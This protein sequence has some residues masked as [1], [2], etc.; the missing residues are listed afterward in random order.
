MALLATAA[1]FAASDSA[2]VAGGKLKGVI[3]NGIASFKGIPFAA[4][5]VGDL[6]WRAPQP[7]AAWQGVRAADHFEHDCMQRKSGAFGPWSAEFIAKDAME[8]GSS[9]DCL[10]LNVWTAAAHPSEKRPVFVWIYGGGF[11]SGGASVPVYD[12][13]GLASKG[14]V[15]VVINYRVGI[16]GFMA[17]PELTKESGRNASGNYGLLDM[18]AALRWVKANAGA[19][20]GDASNVTI[21]GQSAGAF[22]VNYLVASPLAKGLFNRAI[23][24]SG[25]VFN[26]NQTL[27]Q[28]EANGVSF[29]QKL[30]AANLAEMRAKSADAVQNGGGRGGPIVDGYFI[31]K[32]VAELFAGG[33]QNDVPVILGWNADDGTSF[34]TP[35]TPEAFRANAAR[36]YG[37]RAEEF[38]KA[39]PSGT[40]A[41]ATESQRALS[42]I[43]TFAWQSHAWAEA[44]SRSGKSKIYLY[45]FDRTAPG[46]PEQ[47]KY[48]AHHTGEVPYAL[49]TLAMWDRPFEAADRKLADEMSSYWVNFARTGNPN[50]KALPAWPAYS[51]IHPQSMELSTNVHAIPTPDE[52][53][54]TFFDSFYAG[55]RAQR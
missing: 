14:L 27:R 48:G 38:L 10:Y 30:G 11:N 9:E 49:N 43:P 47:T 31:P 44:Q 25:G 53:R 29:Q 6:R 46:T 33:Q 7:P 24:E 50:G 1:A 54:F 55:R 19:F 2:Q 4:P 13:E 42:R 21:A 22:A 39:F 3:H 36:L 52:A 15:V 8:G 23:A 16:F 17:H 28:G 12:G 34:N 18:V 37:D 51:S 20:G 26:S 35:P 40:Q 32:S 41:E 45:F 5:P